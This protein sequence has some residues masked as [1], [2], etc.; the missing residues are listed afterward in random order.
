M[1]AKPVW[2]KSRR[3]GPD[4]DCVEIAHLDGGTVV[5]RDSKNADGPTLTF[6]PAEWDAFTTSIRA[7]AFG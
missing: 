2:F 4:R 5:V 3:S 1:N 6:T 7:G